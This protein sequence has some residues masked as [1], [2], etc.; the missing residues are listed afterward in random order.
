MSLKQ[1]SQ[2]QALFEISFPKSGPFPEANTSLILEL[3]I[4]LLFI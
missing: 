4:I 2:G 1:G 3:F